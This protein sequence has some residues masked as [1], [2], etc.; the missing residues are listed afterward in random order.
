[1]ACVEPIHCL[2][3]RPN[4]EQAHSYSPV[5]Y[6]RNAESGAHEY[7]EVAIAVCLIHRQRG[8]GVL[9]GAPPRSLQNRGHPTPYW[10]NAPSTQALAVGRIFIAANSGSFSPA[11]EHLF[12]GKKPIERRRKTR[13]NRHLHEDFGDFLLRQSN[14]QRRLNMYLQLRGGSAHRR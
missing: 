4:R 12:C 11:T 6:L 1:M 5:G 7:H 14:V 10:I 3:H 13:I 2:I 9:G 8:L